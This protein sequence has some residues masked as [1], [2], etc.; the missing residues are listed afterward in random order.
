MRAHDGSCKY[1]PMPCAF[2]TLCPNFAFQYVF[3]CVGVDVGISN[4]S[5]VVP[6][7][8]KP[9]RHVRRASN[10]KKRKREHVCTYAL[11]AF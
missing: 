11:T 7:Y 5:A 4:V 10:V 9:L 8:V 6:G 3:K 1:S 2:P